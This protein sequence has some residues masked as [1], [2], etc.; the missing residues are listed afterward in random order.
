MEPMTPSHADLMTL[1]EEQQTLLAAQ[2]ARIDAL[3]TLV[4]TY[5]ATITRLEG[6][7][8][9]LERGDGP[10]RG[11]PGHKRE[12][13]DAPADA[14]TPRRKRTENHA[15]RRGEPTARVV[16]AVDACP[17]CGLRLAG[18]SVARTREVIEVT[19]T[20]ATI[21]EHVSLECC[22][23][24]CQQRRTPSA[25]L[26]GIVVGQSRLGIGLVSLIATLRE[27][28]RLPYATIQTYLASVHG[29]H[30][31][32]GALVGALRQVAQAGQASSEALRQ[33]VRTSRV[34]Y[35]DE[36]G[37]RERGRN[38][39]LWSFSP[40]DTRY[41]TYGRRTKEMVDEVLGEDAE[42]VLVTDCYPAYDHYPGLQQ[43]CWAHLLRDIHDLSARD[44]ADT[45][46]AEWATEARAIYDRAMAV[47]ETLVPFPA[48]A[49]ERQRARQT[50]MAD[51]LAVSQPF[52][53]DAQAAQAVLCRRIEKHLASLFVFVLD[54]AVPLTNN[55]AE[56]SVRHLV[57]A[58]KISGGTR[59][60]TGTADKLVV[61]S[62]FGT[63][64]LRGLNPYDACRKLLSSQA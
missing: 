40:P 58:R 53:A 34:V 16:H 20:P 51:L 42:G 4:T 31:S 5:E 61:A 48:E 10:P 33:A 18:G 38:G 49:P 32:V 46:L 28:A 13:S 9:M 54:P 52:L 19:P 44:P 63:W 55:A 37:W 56:R 60:E 36:T 45:S 35:A 24:A 30:L 57:I 17:V 41:Y 23:P 21:T 6:R 25:E 22:C 15:R 26:A 47:T 3:E 7:L 39:Y 64:R 12:Q 59:S 11:M 2:Q 29:I 14:T 27:E 43:K 50:L 8:R 62:L 1:V